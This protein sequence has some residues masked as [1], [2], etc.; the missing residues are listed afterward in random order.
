MVHTILLCIKCT[1]CASMRNEKTTFRS[2]SLRERSLRSNSLRERS[3]RSNSLRERSLRSSS[4]GKKGL[5][6]ENPL[7][8]V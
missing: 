2:N 3:L 6:S 8:V 7:F 4:L 1:L 5:I